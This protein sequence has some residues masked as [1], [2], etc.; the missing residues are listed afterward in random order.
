MC[1][2]REWASEL[3]RDVIVCMYARENERAGNGRTKSNEWVSEQTNERAGEWVEC[4]R[5]RGF[6][7]LVSF[8][9]IR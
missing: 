6:G 4:E 5:I 3:G 2:A 8:I 7:I 9:Y 1:P